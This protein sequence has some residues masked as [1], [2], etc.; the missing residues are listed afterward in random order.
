M[1]GQ[2]SLWMVG[3]ALFTLLYGALEVGFRTS[4]SRRSEAEAQ[5]SDFLA[6]A[7]L[8]LLA[9]L[10][11]FT[12]SLAL[13]RHEERRALVIGEANAIGTSWLRIQ[14]IDAADRERLKAPFVRYAATRLA[15]SRNSDEGENAAQLYQH[16]VA[17][18]NEVW[19]A[20][21]VALANGE[22]IVDPKLL[23]DPL[24]T[25]FDLAAEREERRNAHLPAAMLAILLL[26]MILSTALVGWRL[27]EVGRRLMV[28][29]GLTVLLTTLA[30]VVTLD[31]DHGQT[32]AITVSQRAM[33]AAVAPILASAP[34]P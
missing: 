16:T 17:K 33:E 1:F 29:S 4:R 30:V 3:I 28:P 27:G 2:V 25:S 21:M 22:A 23:L 15:W 24:N 9:L 5:G 7:T 10:L 32:G 8:G 12:F 14:A 11:G 26:Y 6:S 13:S 34:A 19:Q 20:A 18:Q 31:L